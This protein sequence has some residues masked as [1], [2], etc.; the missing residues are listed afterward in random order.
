MSKTLWEEIIETV[1]PLKRKIKGVCTS[2]KNHK[3]KTDEDSTLEVSFLS[4]EDIKAKPRR[5]IFEKE[6]AIADGSR[7]D[8]TTVDKIKSGKFIPEAI[9]DLHGKT[10]DTAYQSFI[11]FIINNYENNVRKL[12]V[13][14]GKG[15]SI[16][17][18]GIIRAGFNKWINDESVKGMI[19]YIGLAPFKTQNDGAFHIYLRKK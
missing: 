2:I 6:I 3:I 9:L 1:K 12:L 13:I 8:K 11:S 14:T 18:A 5:H 16:K 10:L 15:N 7:V 19:L 4:L 17:G